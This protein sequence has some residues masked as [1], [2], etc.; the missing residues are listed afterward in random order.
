MD[1]MLF[2]FDKCVAWNNDCWYMDLLH[3]TNVATNLGSDVDGDFV[4]GLIKVVFVFRFYCDTQRRSNVTGP[5]QAGFYCTV[6][7]TVANPTDGVQGNAFLLFPLKYFSFFSIFTK[8]YCRGKPALQQTLF[9]SCTRQPLPQGIVL[10]RPK[11]LTVQ[12]S[13]RHLHG[14]RKQRSGRR[15]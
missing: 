9:S 12:M 5:C 3:A 7:C 6:G 10:P 8:F 15:L 4:T 2:F 13:T 14:R 11:W 1:V